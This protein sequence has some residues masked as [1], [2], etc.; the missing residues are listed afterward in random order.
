[1]AFAFSGTSRIKLQAIVLPLVGLALKDE[2]SH[3]N[4]YDFV[5]VVVLGDGHPVT[6]SFF[7]HSSMAHSGQCVKRIPRI[8]IHSPATNISSTAI[9][10]PTR[11]F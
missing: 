4:L 3:L 10:S 8:Y 2:P 11:F 5:V 1:M 6:G 9:I 7:R